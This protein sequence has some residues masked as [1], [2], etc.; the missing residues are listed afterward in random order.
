MSTS[1]A[2]IDV[3][4]VAKNFSSICGNF[5]RFFRRSGGSTRESFDGEVLSRHALD[6][7]SGIDESS[8]G[9]VKIIVDAYVLWGC[10][11]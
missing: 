5:P 4:K 6:V 7:I 1:R 11:E 8:L 2:S 10:F 9:S 3:T